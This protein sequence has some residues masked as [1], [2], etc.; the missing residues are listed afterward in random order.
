[1]TE[2]RRDLLDQLK[3]DRSGD[4]A[5]GPGWL[6]TVAGFGAGLL[7]AGAAAFL[8]WPAQAP[9]LAQAQSQP[10]GQPAPA[11]QP[12]QGASPAAPAPRPASSALTASGF[13][14]ARRLATVS[15][16]ITGR[17]TELLVEEGMKVEEGQVIARLDA[18]LA[19]F[20]LAVAR[21]SVRAAEANAE[22]AA[23][24]LARLQG[25][26]R[27]GVVSESALSEAEGRAG[28]TRAQ[29]DL[30]SAQASRAE[31]L[32]AKYEVR[33]PFAGV[34]TTKDAQPGEIVSPAAAGGASTRSGLC[35]IVDMGSLEIEVD[36]SET[37]IARVRAGQPVEA[38]LDAYP[39]WKIPASVAAIIPAA[40][41][42]KATVKVRIKLDAADARILPDMAAKV[43]FLETE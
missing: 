22:A 13:V 2:N 36:V 32:L 35:T 11:A 15:S 40:D 43:S 41:R 20:D 39:D 27:G 10:A 6:G 18:T 9:V 14:T 29:A 19:Q 7:A 17:V 23:R 12:A 25:L 26:P 4:P 5:R 8:L 1:V 37:F 21:A 16:E 38:T 31:A 3:L 28:S 42:S 33:A 24:D 30:A 34:V